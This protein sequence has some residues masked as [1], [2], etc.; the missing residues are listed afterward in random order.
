MGR[1]TP[2]ADMDSRLRHIG[3]VR[4]FE[5]EV[6]DRL[7]LSNRARGRVHHC[8]SDRSSQTEVLAVTVRASFLWTKMTKVYS[9]GIIETT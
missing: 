1:K 2:M 4:I 8:I 9:F 3:R 6:V 7:G 5:D